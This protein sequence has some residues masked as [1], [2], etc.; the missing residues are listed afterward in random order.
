MTI[1]NRK[2][3]V[4]L[5]GMPARKYVSGVVGGEGKQAGIE[6][7][8]EVPFYGDKVGDVAH[9]IEK[10]PR[11]EEGGRG[12]RVIRVLGHLVDDISLR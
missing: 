11:E 1:C 8:T 3:D 6:M 7:L 10:V 12:S 9:H 2:F 5:M 4:S